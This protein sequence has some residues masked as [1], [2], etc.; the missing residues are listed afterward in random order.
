MIIEDIPVFNNEN[1]NQ[2]LRLYFNWYC[3]WK[4]LD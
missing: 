4:K 3:L 1:S 2:Q